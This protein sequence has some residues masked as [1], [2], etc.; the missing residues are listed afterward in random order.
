MSPNPHELMKPSVGAVIVG[1]V[2]IRRGGH[3]FW[4]HVSIGIVRIPGDKV[5][6]AHLTTLISCQTKIVANGQKP[7]YEQFVLP[8][9]LL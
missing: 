6:S 5:F 3:Y 2:K 1:V 9:L 8:L 7:V 4:I